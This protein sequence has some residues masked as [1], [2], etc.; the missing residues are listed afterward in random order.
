MIA[1]SF[2]NMSDKNLIPNI[3]VAETDTTISCTNKMNID[4]EEKS[5]SDSVSGIAKHS[6][7]PNQ[8]IVLL[9]PE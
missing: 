7:T 2:K 1:G 6:T 8:N 9:K 3:V 5:C 4:D